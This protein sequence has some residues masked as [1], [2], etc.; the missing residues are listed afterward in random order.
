MLTDAGQF[1]VLPVFH[2]C[3]VGERPLVSEARTTTTIPLT[4]HRLGGAAVGAGAGSCWG[5]AERSGAKTV[6]NVL[7]CE[8]R[9]AKERDGK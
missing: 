9:Q 8:A 2:K 3:F 6:V 1:P 4:F 5:P 7:D